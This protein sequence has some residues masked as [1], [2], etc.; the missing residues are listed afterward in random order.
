MSVTQ[1]AE[2]LKKQK[3]SGSVIA[4]TGL[5]SAEKNPAGRV[6]TSKAHAMFDLS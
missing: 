5:G 3:L 6:F 4:G 1:M 2:I